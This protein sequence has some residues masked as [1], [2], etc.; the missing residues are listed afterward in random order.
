MSIILNFF[1]P[2]FL[3]LIPFR[4]ISQWEKF[5]ERIFWKIKKT[6]SKLETINFSVKV[7]GV[8]FSRMKKRKIREKDI[9]QE[10][11]FLRC[12]YVTA[13]LKPGKKTHTGHLRLAAKVLLTL[14]F[15]PPPLALFSITPPLLFCRWYRLMAVAKFLLDTLIRLHQSREKREDLSSIIFECARIYIYTYIYIV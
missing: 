8:L 9:L 2:Y 10:S 4:L 3:F 13:S 12:F 15:F 6:K 1:F 5:H 11:S 7:R 14:S